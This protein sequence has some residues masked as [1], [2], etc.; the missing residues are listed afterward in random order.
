MVA[1]ESE[2]LGDLNW[3]Q[4]RKIIN[5]IVKMKKKGSI[6]YVTVKFNRKN[7]TALACPSMC[8]GVLVVTGNE[9]QTAGPRAPVRALELMYIYMPAVL[10]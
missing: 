9:D 5:T 10:P 3:L 8:S 6:E 2:Y 7:D 1:T 4:E